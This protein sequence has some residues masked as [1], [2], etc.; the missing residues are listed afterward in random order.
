[1]VTKH[2]TV[3]VTGQ[4]GIV[5]NLVSFFC[6]RSGDKSIID[7]QPE[8]TH[9]R[10]ARISAGLSQQ[11][12]AELANTSKQTIERLENRKM[13]L[14]REWASRLAPYLQRSAEELVFQPAAVPL[15]GTVGAGS[16]FYYV[17]EE[18][19]AQDWVAMPPGASEKTVAVE[20][21]GD[22]FGPMLN[23]WVAYY[24]RRNEPPTENLIG[25][26]C[27]VATTDDRIMIKKLW[28]GREAGRWD[29]WAPNAELM[30]DQEVIWAAQVIALLPRIRVRR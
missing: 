10:R 25:E 11:K 17:G 26:I 16:S 27:I 22:S 3:P 12:L 19:P 28:R 2:V 18:P 29:L 30:Q 20:L 14:T 9:L 21:Q 15:L 1:M 5:T 6:L 23:G 24:D 8:Q 4:E 7:D 13:K